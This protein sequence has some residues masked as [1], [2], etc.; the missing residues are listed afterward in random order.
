[1]AEIGMGTLYDWNKSAVG[2]LEPLKSTDLKDK[3]RA[4]KEKTFSQGKYYMLLCHEKR[5]YTIFNL[6][7]DAVGHDVAKKA[8]NELK[9]C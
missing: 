9:E 2:L 4:I 8:A 3:M 6:M 1:M 7:R 5:D